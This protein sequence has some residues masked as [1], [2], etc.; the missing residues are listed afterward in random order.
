M[1]IHDRIG[2]ALIIVTLGVLGFFGAIGWAVYHFF[3]K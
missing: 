1:Q 2:L 3:I